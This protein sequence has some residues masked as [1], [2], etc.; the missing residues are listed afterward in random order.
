MTPPS[1]QGEPSPSSRRVETI[2]DVLTLLAST[3]C[4]LWWLD[5]ALLITPTIT[6]GG[7]TASHYSSAWW[8]RHE[9]LPRG[10][11]TGWMPGNYAGFPLFQ[12]YF[13]LP[14][15]LIAVL[16]TVVGLPVAFKWGTIAGLL[17]L[18]VA[19]YGCFRL[20]GWRFPAPALAAAFST[21]FLLHEGNSMWGA[22]L[23]STLAGEF[24]YSIAT[25][26]LVLFAGTLYRGALSGRGMAAN[27]VLLA[28]I[29]LSHAYALL[30][31]APWGAYLLLFHPRGRNNAP[32][33]AGV[34]VLAF[35]LMGFWIVPL[36][37]YAPYTTGYGVIWPVRGFAHVF[38]PIL[39]PPLV[40]LG[41]GVLVALMRRRAPSSRG[42]FR[43]DHRFAYLATIV[44][45][46]AL[47]YL[48]AWKI[49]VVD[50]RFLPFVQLFAGLLAALPVAALLRRFARAEPPRRG[51]R[52]VAGLTALAVIAALSWACLHV[53]VA[54]GWARWNYGGFEAAPG[55]PS[56]RAV[57]DALRRTAASPRVAYEHTSLHDEA[58]TLR[59]FESLPLFAGAS[60]LEG[61]YMQ[62]SL[63]A[64]FVFYVQSEISRIPSC[65]L[66]PYH[67]GRLD[68]ARAAEH[69]RLFNV[70]EVIVRGERVKAEL[71][72][73]PEFSLAEE[74]PPYQVFRIA[75]TDGA[76][77]VP[78]RYRPVVLVGGSWKTE[79]FNWFKRPGSG[80]VPLVRADSVG[81]PDDWHR[82]EA[83][84]DR[85]PR[86]ALNAAVEVSS[87]VSAEEIRIST[88]R[89]GH[90]LLVKVSYH[91][92]WR[93]EGAAGVW[94]ASPSFMLVVPQQEEVRLVYGRGRAD[95]VG[96][97]LTTLGLA[98][99]VIV[100]GLAAR[101]A[102][103]SATS[104]SPSPSRSPS[105]SP[106]PSPSAPAAPVPSPGAEVLLDRVFRRRRIWAPALAI[107]LA[108]GAVALRWSRVDPWVLHRQGLDLFHGGS[109]E[110]A[111][112]LLLRAIAA[113][114][115]SP[116]AHYSDYYHALAAH[117]AGRPAE[118]VSR[119]RDFVR[120]FPDSEMVPEAHFRIGESLMAAGRYD[121]A[122]ARFLMVIDRF[123]ESA[124]AGYAAEGLRELPAAR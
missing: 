5:P 61:L 75:D 109:Y 92:R 89:P 97:V 58:G 85:V 105:P 18:P 39:W 84:P 6:T 73:S 55:W 52:L 77:V 12:V 4:V 42:A 112:P 14:F 71:A 40:I 106:S 29:G 119:F 30:A 19:A 95:W 20:M 31:A 124:W 86:R 118:T 48:V 78:L 1:F 13:P 91:P 122:A 36:L 107:T 100:M 67:C 9:L 62:S 72:E 27:A 10:R 57:N 3:S 83:L 54:A 98:Y 41:A 87:R 11:L 49:D 16:S 104:P 99:L 15:V 102:G 59:A 79:F 56:F 28:A 22:N 66:V 43:L 47:L 68:A 74:I 37:A 114:P 35:A 24:T 8:L 33:L 17:G 38:P 26:L 46:A 32:Y 116:A 80:D 25:A 51:P 23:S 60:T 120:D 88:S 2:T 94:L 76:Y 103:R 81:I 44:P 111:E 65:P 63:S 70:S 115:T 69:L 123:P 45:G 53:D 64:P 50:I 117:R 101:G 96:I 113:A 108:L 93:A 82:V 21:L 7:D 90:P 34:T 121:D 110:A